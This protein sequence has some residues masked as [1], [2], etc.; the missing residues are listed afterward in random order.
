[1]FELGSLDYIYIGV[2]LVST[3][4]ASIRGGVYETVATLSW[5]VAAVAARFVSPWLDEVFQSWLKLS[6]STIG[7]L[8]ASYFLVFFVILVTFG[9]F[10][11]RLRDRVRESMMN[12][13]DHALGIVFGIIRGIVIMG[14]LY[15]GM[16]WYYSGEKMPDWLANARTRPV[17]QVTVKTIHSWF[18]PGKNK[19]LEQDLEGSNPN[20]RIY[21]QTVEIGISANSVISEEPIIKS[22]EPKAD[23]KK[24]S[25][26]KNI[27][28][29]QP[30]P[31]TSAQDSGYAEKERAE[32]EKQLKKLDVK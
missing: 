24:L 31:L 2:L 16:I 27:V 4:W 26:K 21:E 22:P 20:R 6:E 25:E 14:F 12:V 30:L 1:M 11:Q 10:N 23:S 32:L 5:V 28:V 9:F 8:V 7:T 17:M 29:A 15:W 19:L 3:I 18:I 13:T